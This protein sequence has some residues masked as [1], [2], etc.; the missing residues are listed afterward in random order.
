MSDIECQSL[1]SD[2]LTDGGEEV[3]K[4]GEKTFANVPEGMEGS[5]Q[6]DNGGSDET[7]QHTDVLTQLC[8]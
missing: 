8:V 3:G 2:E 6:K 5:L 4:E 7:R 1:L